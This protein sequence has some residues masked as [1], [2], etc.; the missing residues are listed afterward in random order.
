MG[1]SAKPMGIAD[2]ESSVRRALLQ[3]FG[4][5]IPTVLMPAH[6]D[7][8]GMECATLTGSVEFL[9]NPCKEKSLMAAIDIA[10]SIG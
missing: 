7:K 6:S 1:E 3:A 2:G 4:R 8:D 9:N 5:C 10:R